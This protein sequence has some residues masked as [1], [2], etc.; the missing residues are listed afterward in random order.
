MAYGLRLSR[1]LILRIYWDNQPQ[2]S[3]ECPLGDFFCV[4]W[5]PFA[6]VSSLPIAVNPNNALSV[7][8]DLHK[9]QTSK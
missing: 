6:Q 9:K 7:C 5:G 3:V 4:G 8:V 2:A 1:N